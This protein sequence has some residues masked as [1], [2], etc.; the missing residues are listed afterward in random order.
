MIVLE[1]GLTTAP[2]AYNNHT[3]TISRNYLSYCL[4]QF[5]LDE[6]DLI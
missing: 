2:V 3:V 5:N 6:V 4:K 1:G